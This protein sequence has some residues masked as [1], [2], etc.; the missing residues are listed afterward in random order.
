MDG[1]GS[2]AFAV[3]G[4]LY[5]ST[6]G[7]ALQQLSEDDTSWRIVAQLERARFFHR[8]LPLSDTQ[9]L[10]IGGASMSKGKFEEVDVLDVSAS[11]IH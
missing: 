9:L 6:Y 4:R 7:G 2:S 5:V 3:G 11:A 1:F 8:M 10:S